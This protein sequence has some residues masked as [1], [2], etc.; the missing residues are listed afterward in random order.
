MRLVA[1]A[2]FMRLS[3]LKGARGF[4]S[5]RLNK[6]GYTEAQ[7]RDVSITL[8]QMFLSVFALITFHYVEDE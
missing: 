4:F 1:L 2:N 8:K 5:Q 7:P 6:T 3:L